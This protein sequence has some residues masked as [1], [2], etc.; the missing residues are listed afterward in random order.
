MSHLVLITNI[1]KLL[2]P[3]KVKILPSQWIYPF[4]NCP[5]PSPSPHIICVS[6]SDPQ[7]KSKLESFI[8]EMRKGDYSNDYFETYYDTESN[9][10]IIYDEK[11]E[12]YQSQSEPKWGDNSFCLTM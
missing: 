10:E 7:I 9:V 4:V 1:T 11:L 8:D 12:L 6:S 2:A 3:V 5:T